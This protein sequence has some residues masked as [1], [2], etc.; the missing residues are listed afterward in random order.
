MDNAVKDRK[1]ATIGNPTI[2][3]VIKQLYRFDSMEQ[4]QLRL[5]SLK[6]NF[7][8][9]SSIKTEN[10]DFVVWL[11]GYEVTDAELEQGYLGNFAKFICIK[12]EDGKYTIAAE[13]LDISLA[14]HPQKKRPKRRHP[15]WGHQ[16][17]RD[18]KKN[19]IY[20]TLEHALEDLQQL[21]M[22]YP[23]V[24]IP[25]DN[26]L[27][28]MV[29][30]KPEKSTDNPTH[31]YKFIIKPTP[32]GAFYITYKSNEKTRITVPKQHEDE[33]KTDTPSEA[34]A[35]AGYFTAMVSLKKKKRPRT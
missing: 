13:K 22:E 16:V 19:K 32:E 14:K 33:V 1:Y 28:I 18:I 15:D 5:E 6:R 2:N 26:G 24:A 34:K 10:N 11:R 31:K 3:A 29:Y 23:E 7:V 21:Q 17:L 35:P 20:F 25:T 30:E 27:L 12:T 8:V 4:A 9:S